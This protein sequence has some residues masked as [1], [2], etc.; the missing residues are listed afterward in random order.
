VPVIGHVRES[1]LRAETEAGRQGSV[2]ML[3][4]FWRLAPK[5]HAPCVSAGRAHPLIG[6]VMS[7]LNRPGS[8]SHKK[9]CTTSSTPLTPV[10]SRSVS[11]ATLASSQGGR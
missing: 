2:S 8:A 5:S 11:P 3:G 9:R 10:G 6:M 7:S 1:W 4:V